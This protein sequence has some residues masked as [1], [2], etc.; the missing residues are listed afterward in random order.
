LACISEFTINRRDRR[1]RRDR[2]FHSVCSA[3]SAVNGE[4]CSWYFGRRSTSAD[5]DRGVLRAEPSEPRRALLTR[6]H[7]IRAEDIELLLLRNLVPQLLELDGGFDLSLRPQDACGFAAGGDLRPLARGA[8]GSRVDRPGSGLQKARPI[9]AAADQH[10]REQL[11]RR[12][13]DAA[14]LP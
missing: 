1:V 6:C 8:P 11:A 14:P 13:R 3:S 7:R 4:T 9:W 5:L 12:Q 10:L 2:W